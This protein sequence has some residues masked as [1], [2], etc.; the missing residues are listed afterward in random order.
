M[1]WTSL[2]SGGG[3]S[4]MNTWG[5]AIK[6]VS[7]AS[8]SGGSGFDWGSVFGS[9]SGKAS[10]SS[11]ADWGKWLNL[12]TDAYGAAKGGS[13]GS[14][15]AGGGSALSSGGSIWESL[16][17]GAGGAAKAYMDES[18]VK[19]MGK[20]QR[21]TLDFSASL[22]DY[23]DQKDKT[24][25]RAALDTYGQFSLMDRWAPNATKG[26]AVDQPAK[27]EY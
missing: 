27:P 10:S 13:G 1:G 17:A 24:R 5:N 6:G 21:Q 7:G 4:T 8:N 3:N 9:L 26:I 23:Y 12:A 14:S 16:L 15:G 11:G 22:K 18:S 2:F 20:Q 19:E 25:K